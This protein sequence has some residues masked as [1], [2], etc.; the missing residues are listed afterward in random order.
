VESQQALRPREIPSIRAKPGAPSTSW[1]PFVAATLIVDAA[2]ANVSVALA[3]LVRFEGALPR[4][5]WAA[6]EFLWLP[7]TLAL[8]AC[9]LVVGMYAR[10]GASSRAELLTMVV[11][12]NALWLFASAVIAYSLRE[13]ATAYPTA[14]VFLAPAFNATISYWIHVAWQRVRRHYLDAGRVRSAVLVGS[15]PE[16]KRLVEAA[17]A[18]HAFQYRFVAV[19]ED[20]RALDLARVV[21]ETGA[22]EVILANPNLDTRGLL[23]HLV[24]CAGLRVRFKV[25]PSIFESIRAQSRVT[26]IAGVPIVDLFGGEVPTIREVARRV[27]DLALAC[28]GLA[29]TLPFCPLIALAVKVSSPGPVWYSQERVGLHGRSYRLFKFRTMRADAEAGTGPVLATLDDRRVTAVGR[30]LRMTR[31]DEVPQLV[32][33]VVGDMSIVGPRPERPHFVRQ[34]LKSVPAYA[35]RY[36][37][38]PGITGLAQVRGSYATSARNK[39]RYDLVYLENRSLLLDLKILAMTVGVVLRGRGAR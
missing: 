20:D 34:F 5:N 7:T 8:V 11:R 26:V 2:A 30:F 6:V 1:R 21:R 36:N 14:V 22:E 9:Y 4:G 35:Q 18:Q 33:V 19:P 29:V 15:T 25:V 24:Q 38:R 31:L 23:H 39:L 10:H 3:F 27:F 12:G 32:N 16:A 17:S 13:F 37:V 28:V